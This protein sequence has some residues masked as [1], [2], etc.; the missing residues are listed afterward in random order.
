MSNPANVDAVILAAGQSTRMEQPKPL[1]EVG[2][3]TFLERTIH[4]LKNGGCRYVVAVV[5]SND[6]WVQRLADA[7]GAAIVVNDDPASQQIDSL[8][9]GVRAL[10][11]DWDAVAV[12]PVD[13]PL[14]ADA[15]V[16]AIVDVVRADRPALTLP[17]H[18]GVAGHPVVIGRQLESEIFD[19]TWEEGVRSLIMA[20]ARHL[21]EVK[22]VDPAI[23]I[24]IDSKEDYWRYVQEKNR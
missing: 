9:L 17:F 22:V 14:I 7:T 11:P 3:E 18:N 13:I 6:D 2:S 21:R 19:K 16:R 23:L 1:L 24:D 20:H 4:M 10:P 5:N 15:T 8:R 12:L